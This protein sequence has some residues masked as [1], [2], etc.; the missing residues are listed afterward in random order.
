MTNVPEIP[1]W[2]RGASGFLLTI[3][4][5]WPPTSNSVVFSAKVK[6]GELTVTLIPPGRILARVVHDEIAME[7]TSSILQISGPISEL[8]LLGWEYPNTLAIHL[9]HSLIASLREPRRVPTIVV[10]PPLRRHTQQRDF[11]DQNGR[12]QVARKGR[13]AGS[14]RKPGRLHEGSEYLFNSLQEEVAQLR[15]LLKLV[16]AG[17]SYHVRGIASRIRLL[18]IDGDPL[19]L[20]QMCA[21]T[22]EEPLTMFTAAYP[23][24]KLS[25]PLGIHPQFRLIFN[26]NATQL[27]HLLNPIDLDVWLGLGAAQIGAASITNR[28]LLKAIGDTVGSHLD[29]DVHFSISMLRQIVGDVPAG[30]LDMLV[31]Y[32]CRSA[33]LTVQLSDRILLRYRR[34]T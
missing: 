6:D 25:L 27:P 31:Q 34:P 12:A 26:G 20:L 24:R 7:V 16:E 22:I 19:P 32:V 15:D 11:T 30:Q 23:T 4:Q 18:I 9:G 14:H 2:E 10:I 8:C 17:N 21:A 5:P 29:R 28:N 1:T 3:N 13:L 33:D